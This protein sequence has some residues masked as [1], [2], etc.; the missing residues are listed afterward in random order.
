MEIVLALCAGVSVGAVIWFDMECWL[1]LW[2]M[3][4]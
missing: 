2:E 3:I 1:D 4:R